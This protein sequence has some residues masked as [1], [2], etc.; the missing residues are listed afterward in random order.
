[1]AKCNM[2]ITGAAISFF[3][4]KMRHKSTYQFNSFGENEKYDIKN[5]PST[6]IGNH[7][8]ITISVQVAAL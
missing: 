5:N 2:Q 8:P 7:I 6:K 4:G 1:M 3:K